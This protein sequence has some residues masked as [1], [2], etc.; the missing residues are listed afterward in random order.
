[1]KVGILGGSFDP[2]HLGH[3]IIGQETAEMLGLEVLYFVPC[4]TPPH[5]PERRLAAARHRLR[6]LVDAVKGNPRFA[7]SDIELTRPGPSYSLDTL[8]AFR[9]IL[10]ATTELFLV[11]GMDSLVDMG[12]WH[13]PDD[14]FRLARVVAAGRPGYRSED[15]PA[16][17]A[18]RAVRVDVTLTDISSSRVRSFVRDGRSIR[19]LVPGEV[20]AYIQR[21]R[22]Y[23]GSE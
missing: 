19:Y 4:R 11:V 2:V 22:L 6:M 23:R 5:K 10:G 7:L 18:E 9:E 20:A 1:M 14:I 21:E 13:R 8:R 15:V 16:R 17:F 12:S 3:L